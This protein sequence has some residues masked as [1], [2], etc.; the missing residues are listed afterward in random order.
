[1]ACVLFNC[2][3]DKIRIKFTL[4][5]K[6]YVCGVKGFTV[7]YFTFYYRTNI[8]VE[9]NL[10]NGTI[11]FQV[12]ATD[13]DYGNNS[14]ITYFLLPSEYGEKFSIDASSGNITVI[15]NLDRENTSEVTL[16]IQ[17]TGGKFIITTE[18]FVIITDVNDNPPVFTSK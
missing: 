2:A 14:I 13:A 5:Q 18:L 7:S 12:K 1:M 4:A 8:S 17:A 3:C 6:Q 15:G 9:E 11:I 16:R 10:A